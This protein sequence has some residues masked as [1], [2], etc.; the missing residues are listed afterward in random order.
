MV[1]FFRC[2]VTVE[3]PGNCEGDKKDERRNPDAPKKT[4]FGLLQNPH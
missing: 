4:E 2:K 1:L 3:E